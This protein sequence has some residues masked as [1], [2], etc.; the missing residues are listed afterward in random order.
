MQFGATYLYL[1][2]KDFSVFL[3]V[4]DDVTRY[5]AEVQPPLQVFMTSSEGYYFS[6]LRDKYVR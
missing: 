2:L 1:S 5:F 4:W 6:V 3:R